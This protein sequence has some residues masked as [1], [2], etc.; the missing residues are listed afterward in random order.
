MRFPQQL[1]N[2]VIPRSPWKVKMTLPLE[3]ILST[4]RSWK[5]GKFTS[6]CSTCEIC[7]RLNRYFV[8]TGV[9]LKYFSILLLVS[10]ISE[11]IETRIENSFRFSFRRIS[12]QFNGKFHSKI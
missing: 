2:F 8:K 4:D 9:S 7:E 11:N 6:I 12:Q 10:N 1:D 5:V 3:N